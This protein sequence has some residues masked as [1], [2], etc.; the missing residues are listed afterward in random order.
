MK[1]IQACWENQ[2][3]VALLLLPLVGLF[4]LIVWL[5]RIGY[6]WNLLPKQR[7]PV[8]VIV[9]GNIS[10][11]G[12]GK[13]PL[14]LWLAQYLRSLGREVSGANMQQ[15]LYYSQYA[16]IDEMYKDRDEFVILIR[17]LPH[18]VNTYA[19][20]FVD[21]VVSEVNGVRIRNLRDVQ[22]AAQQPTN[23]FHV[24]RFDGTQDTIVLDA[25]ATRRAD[26]EVFDEYDIFSP[27]YF[28]ELQP[29]ETT[30][31]VPD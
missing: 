22:Q 26:T 6:R 18:E 30:K 27:A 23:G 25:D 15:L 24:I 7:L 28:G 31:G 8:P 1:S 14:V 2:N 3:P 9:V 13:T 11:G 5:R 4:C 19:D 20:G 16:K 12:T 10:V 21:G 29:P 17:R